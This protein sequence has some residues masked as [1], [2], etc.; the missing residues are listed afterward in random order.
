MLVAA[1]EPMAATNAGLDGLLCALAESTSLEF[2]D[3]VEGTLAGSLGTV[4]PRVLCPQRPSS[5]P[6]DE[7][8][9]RSPSTSPRTPTAAEELARGP[10]QESDAASAS[11][12]SATLDVPGATDTRPG[13]TTE[14]AALDPL[15]SSGGIATEAAA[16]ASSTGATA[17]AEQAEEAVPFKG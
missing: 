6:A 17:G 3:R 15:L 12:V 2:S 5:E 1:D 9:P 14:A 13:S 11:V 16:A 4:T 7:A 10:C 8:K